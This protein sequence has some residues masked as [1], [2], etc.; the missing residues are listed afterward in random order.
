M[1]TNLCSDIAQQALPAFFQGAAWAFLTLSLYILISLYSS[2]SNRIS[3][4]T[5][6]KWKP[7]LHSG[8]HLTDIR[9]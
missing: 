1:N 3:G 8:H 6:T 7:Y 4:R 9:Q 5:K 2:K